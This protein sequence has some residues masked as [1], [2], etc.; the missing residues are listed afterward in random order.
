MRAGFSA[1]F[2]NGSG[3][4]PGSS[5]PEASPRALTLSAPKTLERRIQL[6]FLPSPPAA[7]AGKP[8]G[9]KTVQTYWRLCST[10]SYQTRS[11]NLKTLLK[12]K[13]FWAFW[14]KLLERLREIS[15]FL[16]NMMMGRLDQNSGS[17]GY[18]LLHVPN[19]NGQVFFPSD[20]KIHFKYPDF[21]TSCPRDSIN[22]FVFH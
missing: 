9:L 19:T 14:W 17:S 6:V 5:S 11:G 7:I 10:I 20:E 12:S 8:T 15:C 4:R 18:S 1:S 16:I 3:V 21:V 2:W 22:Y 13:M